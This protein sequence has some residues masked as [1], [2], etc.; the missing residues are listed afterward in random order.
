MSNETGTLKPM[1]VAFQLL[2]FLTDKFNF[3]FKVIHPKRDVVGSSWDLDGSL[4]ELVNTS[5]CE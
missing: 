5:V 1:G 2:E 3:T 4:I